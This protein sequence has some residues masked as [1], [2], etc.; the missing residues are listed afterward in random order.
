MD[1]LQK[2]FTYHKHIVHVIEDK[3]GEATINK[4]ATNLSKLT[5][6][7]AFSGIDTPQIGGLLANATGPL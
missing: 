5:M 7:S 3:G 2:A 1:T 4:M 6:S